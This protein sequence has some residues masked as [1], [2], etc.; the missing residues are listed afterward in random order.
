M[1][2]GAVTSGLT[3]APYE[4][5]PSWGPEAASALVAA[6]L[7]SGDV[8]KRSFNAQKAYKYASQED[9]IAASDVLAQAGLSLS[10]ERSGLH[11]F[12]LPAYVDGEGQL[13]PEEGVIML[14]STYR[15]EHGSTGQHRLL[16]WECPVMPHKG[17]PLD[18]ALAAART[19]SLGYLLRDLL[20]LPR[21]E[22][23]ADVDQR[24]DP[25]RG[26]APP[27]QPARQA[28]V[29]PPADAKPSAS[30]E[31]FAR[32]IFQ[33][34]SLADLEALKNQIAEAGLTVGGPGKRLGDQFRARKV[35]LAAPKVEDWGDK[36]ISINKHLH[37]AKG[38]DAVEVAASE[39]RAAQDAGMPD[40]LVGPIELALA[41]RRAQMTKAASRPA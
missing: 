2:T 32:E 39:L 25:P 17:M 10:P 1:N 12:T 29:Q 14:S 31:W 21:V 40:S 26:Q 28:A 7:A 3:R 27:R 37:E 8:E 35:E 23:G 18:K 15:L 38:L 6:Q 4:H 9:M 13:Q 20:L 36:A 33:A 30:E 41:S 24:P 11:N 19:Y 34:K 22:A 16:E 5:N